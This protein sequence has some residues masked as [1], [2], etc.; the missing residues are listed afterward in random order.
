MGNVSKPLIALLVGT[1]AFF[2]L[3]TVALKG[4]ASGGASSKSLGTYQSAI[5]KAHHAASLSNAVNAAHGADP[6]STG[7]A[8]PQ[9][10]T[11]SAPGSQAASSAAPAVSSRTRA[12]KSSTSSSASSH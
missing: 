4:G 2:A 7:A 11:A 12:S 8:N 1:V 6:Q 9:G 10:A 3:W 5:D